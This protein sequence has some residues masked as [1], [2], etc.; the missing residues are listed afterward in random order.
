MQNAYGERIS[1]KDSSPVPLYVH[2][3]FPPQMLPA[4]QA[5]ID[6]WQSVIGRPVFRIAQTGYQSSGPRQ[7]G[8]N[9]IYWMQNWEAEKATEQARTSVY[10]VGDQIREAD[11]RLNNK[12]FNFYLGQ[13]GSSKDVHMES[14]LVHELGHVLGLKHKDDSQ[15]VMGTYLSGGTIRTAISPADRDNIKCEYN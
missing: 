4:L 15:S 11:V 13:S 2:T 7:D 1:W 3:S 8:V 5:A 10:W 12:N 14:L 9:V 6:H